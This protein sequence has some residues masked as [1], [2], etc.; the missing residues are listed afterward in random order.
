M[1][2]NNGVTSTNFAAQA[3]TRPNQLGKASLSGGR[4]G[5]FFNT[6][7]FQP[8]ASGT[9]GSEAKNSTFGPHYRHVDFSVFKLFPIYRESTLEFRAEAFNIIN[10]TNFANPNATINVSPNQLRVQNYPNSGVTPNADGT[11]TVPGDTYTPQ[12]SQ[13]GSITSTSANYVPRQI[14]FALKY[15]F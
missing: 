10:T 2:E 11:I 4:I 9:L 8:Q 5:Q 6:A 14:Q 3:T 15:Q 12:G 13:F 1:L 7:L